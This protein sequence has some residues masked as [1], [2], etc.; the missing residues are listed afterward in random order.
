MHIVINIFQYVTEWPNNKGRPN[1]LVIYPGPVSCSPNVHG[2][3]HSA[4]LSS[5]LHIS[6]KMQPDLWQ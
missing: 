6:T 5:M 2:F 4:G 3:Y 1:K